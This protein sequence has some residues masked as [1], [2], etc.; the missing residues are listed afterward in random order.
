MSTKTLF[1]HVLEGIEDNNAMNNGQYS[2]WQSA[3][4]A[5]DAYGD[6]FTGE[7][8]DDAEMTATVGALAM[9][10]ASNGELRDAAIDAFNRSVWGVE[11]GNASGSDTI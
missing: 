6:T 10:I 7:Q 5:I 4:D 3:Q 9:I 8:P 2:D 1:K 11:F